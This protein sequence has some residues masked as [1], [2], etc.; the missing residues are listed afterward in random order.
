MKLEKHYFWKIQ[1]RDRR[2]D[3]GAIPEDLDRRAKQSRAVLAAQAHHPACRF[4]GLTEQ[5]CAVLTRLS[6]LEAAPPTLW[7]GASARQLPLWCGSGASCLPP[8]SCTHPRPLPG[9]ASMLQRSNG[10]LAGFSRPAPSL[11]QTSAPLPNVRSRSGRFPRPTN[12]KR[13]SPVP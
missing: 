10:G 1:A 7:R 8:N 11:W 13:A 5:R 6:G 9:S 2:R 4:H 3:V 12:E